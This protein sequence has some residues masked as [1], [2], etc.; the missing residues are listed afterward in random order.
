MVNTWTIFWRHL[1][2][3]LETFVGDIRQYL[4]KI[5]ANLISELENIVWGNLWTIFG[6]YLD[7]IW[8][9][10]GY[11]LENGWALSLPYLDNI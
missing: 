3:I 1:D 7:N 6:Q 4:D 2:N 8:T 10:F 9:I 11:Y 5:Y